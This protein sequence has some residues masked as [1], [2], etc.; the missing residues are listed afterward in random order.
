MSSIG[1]I[2]FIR[3]SGPQ[4]PKLASFIETIDRPGVDGEA[5]R[6]NAKKVQGLQ[7]RSI[8]WVVNIAAANNA[9]DVY[10]ALKGSL[11]TVVDD[12]ARSV[13]NVMVIDVQVNRVRTILTSSPSGYSH[14]VE[15]TWLLKP[16]AAP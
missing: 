3:L 8:E 15:G 1:V 7:I 14:Q 4:I 2:T 5:F 13:A 12:L 9:I 6:E 10:S 16:T 11:V